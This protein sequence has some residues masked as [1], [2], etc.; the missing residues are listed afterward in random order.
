MYKIING[1][2][3]YKIGDYGTISDKEFMDEKLGTPYYISPELIRN[4][5]Y[6]NK[7]DIWSMGILFDFI[8]Y[9]NFFYTGKDEVEVL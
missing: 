2:K 5:F 7:I 8:I 4:N 9:G 3:I 6:D 1:K